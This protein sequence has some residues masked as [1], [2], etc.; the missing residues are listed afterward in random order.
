[1]GAEPLVTI[2][3][4]GVEGP[5][6]SDRALELVDLAKRLRLTRLQT[7]LAL[8]LARDPKRN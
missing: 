3:S 7:D 4:L 6:P 8:A 5:F 2:R 1:M